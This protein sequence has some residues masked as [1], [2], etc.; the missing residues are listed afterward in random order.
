MYCRLPLS[1]T[2]CAFSLA[3]VSL[4]HCKR[5]NNPAEAEGMSAEDRGEEHLFGLDDKAFS[6]KHS[7]GFSIVS[8]RVSALREVCHEAGFAL[9]KKRG[10]RRHTKTGVATCQD[11]ECAC[12][13]TYKAAIVPQGRSMQTSTQLTG[14][15]WKA[16]LRL[17]SGRWH[18]GFQ[19]KTHNH[20]PTTNTPSLATVR[21]WSTED[22]EDLKTMTEG[23]S[24]ARDVL[25]AQA[26]MNGSCLLTERDIYSTKKKLG[27]EEHGAET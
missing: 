20:A 25:T 2:K 15:W 7:K 23:G 13:G 9:K 10:N 21:T 3:V 27:A 16:V 19:C 14:C 18:V 8:D 5:R 11:Y 1:S 4:A 26:A 22:V 6:Q 24:K 12:A 17:S